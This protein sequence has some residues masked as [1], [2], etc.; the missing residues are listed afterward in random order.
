MITNDKVQLVEFYTD[1]VKY[2][3]TYVGKKSIFTITKRVK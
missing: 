2:T 3:R 1:G